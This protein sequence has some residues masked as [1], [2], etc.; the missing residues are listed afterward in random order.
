M[1]VRRLRSLSQRSW[2][3]GGRR[4][5]VRRLLAGLAEMTAPGRQVPS[6]PDH[7]LPD[8]VAVLGHDALAEPGNGEGV[9]QLVRDALDRTK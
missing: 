1:L 2:A 4:E 5:A 3:V 6:L 7:A 8:A 9:A